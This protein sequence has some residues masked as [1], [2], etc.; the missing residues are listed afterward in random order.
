MSHKLSITI[1]LSLFIE[2]LFLNV[3]YTVQFSYQSRTCH[4]E[5]ERNE[6]GS[7]AN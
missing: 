2:P 5:S 7:R 1:N 3:T 6:N 4:K